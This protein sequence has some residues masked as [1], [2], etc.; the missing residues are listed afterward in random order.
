MRS[1]PIDSTKHDYYGR[2]CC[3]ED[4]GKPMRVGDVAM[5]Q[6][7]A[8]RF[9]VVDRELF[10]HKRCVERALLGA[11][12]ESSEVTEAVDKIKAS[13]ARTGHGPVGWALGGD[14]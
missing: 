4:C 8:D 12:A 9:A 13:I 1:F 2:T 5:V 7:K 11:P 14:E 6:P 10:W 3:D